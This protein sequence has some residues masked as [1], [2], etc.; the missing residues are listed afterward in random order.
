[1]DELI[2]ISYT[3]KFELYFRQVKMSTHPSLDVYKRQRQY[4]H[5]VH[6]PSFL[7]HSLSEDLSERNAAANHCP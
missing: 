7:V 6:L 5:K 3:H 1:M 4:C 2:C